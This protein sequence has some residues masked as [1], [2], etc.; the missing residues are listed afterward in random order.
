M[1]IGK[2]VFQFSNFQGFDFFFQAEGTAVVADILVWR[3]LGVFKSSCRELSCASMLDIHHR[4]KS[5]LP[6]CRP[7]VSH[8]HRRIHSQGYS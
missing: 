7:H 5:I 2:L 3:V 1:L 8:R 4:R 6:C